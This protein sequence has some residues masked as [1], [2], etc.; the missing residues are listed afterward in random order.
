MYTKSPQLSCH[1][2]RWAPTVLFKMLSRACRATGC[3]ARA[4]QFFIETQAD[5]FSAST[6]SNPHEDVVS[7]ASEPWRIPLPRSVLRVPQHGDAV[8]AAMYLRGG[9]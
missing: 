6:C 4:D 3:R 9:E 8:Q 5:N 2:I 7:I 1:T